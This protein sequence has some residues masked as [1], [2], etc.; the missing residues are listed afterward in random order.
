MIITRTPYRIS[1]FGGGSDYP[2]WY[3]KKGG[4]VVSFSI[5]KFCYISLRELPPFFQH[6]YRVSYSKI[7]LT[8]KVEEITHPAVR[9]AIKIFSP[10]LSLEVQHQGDLPASSGVGSSSAFA[11]GIIKALTELNSQSLDNKLIAKLAIDFEQNVLNENVGSQDQIAC[12]LGGLNLIEFGPGKEWKVEPILITSDAIAEMESS[13][14]LIYS[15]IARNSSRISETFVKN[16]SI[17]HD[18]LNKSKSLAYECKKL[19][20]TE[21][22][23]VNI[24]H[25]LKEAWEIKQKLNPKSITPV[26]LE[27]FNRAN[28]AG[29]IGGK[30]L[31]AGGGGF[32]LFWVNPKN[33][34]VFIENMKP[35]VNVPFKIMN[36]GTSRIL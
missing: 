7:E 28:A 34:E 1:L 16:I 29:A 20:E 22:N 33:R 30:V 14:V 13:M 35:C 19:L 3:L 36:T 8:K 10:E 15:G 4:A 12:A 25:M 23:L 27:I 17:N 24:G 26:L 18:S 6:K 32:C 2:Q 31:G 11:V 21:R 5:D 9:E